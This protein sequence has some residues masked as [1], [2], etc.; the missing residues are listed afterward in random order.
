MKLK[1]TKHIQRKKHKKTYTNTI[2]T[3]SNHINKQRHTNKHTI[4]STHAHTHT[5]THSHSHTHKHT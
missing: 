2:K 4:T 1:N 3:L 5:N